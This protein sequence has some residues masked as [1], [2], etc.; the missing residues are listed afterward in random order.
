MKHNLYKVSEYIAGEIVVVSHRLDQPVA[1]SERSASPLADRT[2]PYRS[3][4]CDQQMDW[5]TRLFGIVGTMMVF[6][7]VLGSALFTW[8]AVRPMAVSPSAPLVVEMEP[9]AAPQEPQREVA[10]G[11]K[12]VERSEDQPMQE[13]TMVFPPPS[14]QLFVPA[15]IG[16]TVKEI[17]DPAPTVPETTAP[18]TL[19]APVAA[20][21]SS[22]VKANWEA[23]LLAH[24]E[25]YRSFPPRARA[26]RQQGM[27]Q[28]R[29]RMNRAGTVLTASILRGS[30]FTTLDQAALDTLQRAQPLPPIPKDLPEEI[31]L[32]I[33]VEFYLER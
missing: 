28:L 17:A 27:V 19:A 31:E 29:F 22:E 14:V 4:Y 12:Q 9:L 21:L 7:L 18:K 11:P 32:T 13:P 8:R 20:R 1:Q 25:R 23:R 2:I 26:A 3:R 16:E 33:P 10:T 5:R 6:A 30:G 24:L 15:P